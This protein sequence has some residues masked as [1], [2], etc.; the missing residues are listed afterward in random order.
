MDG[1]SSQI[2]QTRHLQHSTGKTHRQKLTH[3]PRHRTQF[4]ATV[5]AP[6]AVTA[7]NANA[8]LLT[9]LNATHAKRDTRKANTDRAVSSPPVFI[10]KTHDYAPCGNRCGLPV[11]DHLVDQGIPALNEAGPEQS[12]PVSIPL[13]FL[14]LLRPKIAPVG[15]IERI[16]AAIAVACCP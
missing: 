7:K 10:D 13:I 1:V 15:L 9:P 8:P 4:N 11:V 12:G 6:A 3:R 16:V 14:L 5:T 2:R